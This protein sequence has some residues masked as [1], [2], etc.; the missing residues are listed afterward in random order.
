M[1]VCF[2]WCLLYYQPE[3]IYLGVKL[4]VCLAWHFTGLLIT[5]QLK[6][7]YTDSL[8]F[9]NFVSRKNATKLNFT[10]AKLPWHLKMSEN[11]AR[12]NKF[13]NKG[14]DANVSLLEQVAFGVASVSLI[15]ELQ[16]QMCDLVSLRINAGAS[17]Q[18]SGGE[19]RAPQGEERWSDLQKKKC[20]CTSGRGDFSPSGKNP[21]LSGKPLNL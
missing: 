7:S 14:K 20:V 19:R 6:V 10:A 4:V 13:K 5:R 9:L 12:L 21:K 17:P 2:V 11:A 1:F 3:E 16:L 8:F 18:E 15:H